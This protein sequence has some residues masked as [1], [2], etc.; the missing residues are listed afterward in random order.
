VVRGVE[1]RTDPFAPDDVIGGIDD[2]VVIEVTGIAGRRQCPWKDA[3]VGDREIKVFTFD[4][5]GR[6]IAKTTRE[7]VRAVSPR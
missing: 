1:S 2:A 7:R 4:A 5:A 6:A 3:L